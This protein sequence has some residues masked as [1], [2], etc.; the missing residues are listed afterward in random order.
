MSLP[1]D[2]A[3]FTLIGLS[4]I[5]VVIGIGETGFYQRRTPCV[6]TQISPIKNYN[7]VVITYSIKYVM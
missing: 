2:T 6:R 7:T 1:Q 4:I 3:V 5:P